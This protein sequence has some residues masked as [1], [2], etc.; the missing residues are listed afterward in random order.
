MDPWVLS[1]ILK[2]PI[3]FGF[4]IFVAA[5]HYC[6]HKFLPNGFFKQ[7]ILHRWGE[8]RPW[9]GKQGSMLQRFDQFWRDRRA[10]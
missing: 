9:P 1:L 2:A 8:S 7:L 4:L 10:K 5:I 6:L 3:I